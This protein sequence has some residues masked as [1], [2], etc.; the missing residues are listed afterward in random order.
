M[1]HQTYHPWALLPLPPNPQYPYLHIHIHSWWCSHSRRMEQ[2]HVY[3]QFDEDHQALVDELVA[4]LRTLQSPRWMVGAVLCCQQWAYPA[5]FGRDV[6]EGGNQDG[7]LQKLP[8]TQQ[9]EDC[10]QSQPI[11]PS[12]LVGNNHQVYTQHQLYLWWRSTGVCQSHCV[13]VR[14]KKNT[15][16]SVW[17][18]TFEIL[19]SVK[20]VKDPGTCWLTTPIASPQN[21]QPAVSAWLARITDTV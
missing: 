4:P 5:Q 3:C 10:L 2:D 14:L 13:V 1:V 18:P 21:Y 17:R 11:H 20:Q 9:Q 8:S 7:Q 12:L 16:D 19:L 6:R 15:R